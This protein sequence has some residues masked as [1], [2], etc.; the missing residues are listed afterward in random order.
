MCCNE[1]GDLIVCKKRALIMLVEEEGT[2]ICL[3]MEDVFCR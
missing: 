3:S 1:E 2:M